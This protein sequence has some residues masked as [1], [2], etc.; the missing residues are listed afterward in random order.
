MG[1]L[2][3]WIIILAIF[4]NQIIWTAAIPYNFAPDE[5]GHFDVI[6]R[7][8]R[9]NRYP[10]FLQDPPGGVIS[11]NGQTSTSYSALQPLPYVVASLPVFIVKKWIPAR[12]WYLY[13]RLVG[14]IAVTSFALSVYFLL[15][16]LYKDKKTAV[17]GAVISGFI[18]QAS[19]I[20]SYVTSDSVMLA[21][22]GWVTLTTA[23]ILLSR[24]K[25][26]PLLALSWAVSIGAGLLTRYNAY[27]LLVISILFVFR[28]WIKERQ[29]KL[30][31]FS[32]VTI[33]ALSGWWFFCNWLYL[34]DPWGVDVLYRVLKNLRGYE[35]HYYGPIKLLTQTGWLPITAKSAFASFDWNFLFLPDIFYFISLALVLLGLLKV[36]TTWSQIKFRRLLAWLVLVASLSF[37]L[38]V[39]QSAYGSYQPQGRHLFAALPSGLILVITGLRRLLKSNFTLPLTALF[40]LVSNLYSL[41]AVILPRYYAVDL[42]L[43][44]FSFFRQ[45]FWEIVFSKPW[46]FSY[47]TFAL[48]ILAWLILLIS[49]VIVLPGLKRPG[50]SVKK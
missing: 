11:W 32:A 33:T 2:R 37:L 1:K 18:P 5:F 50:I 25:A 43:S 44:G 34:K 30:T 49:V 4:L 42:R 40:I 29:I 24:R 39:A 47:P 48:I 35:F 36:I 14:S 31:A 10:R 22:S 27:P 17:A 23:L 8:A 13:A 20:G 41:T 38:A 9:A 16:V 19:F 15:S 3:L 46:P 7:F 6:E 45:S 12:H 28:R 26:P 21:V